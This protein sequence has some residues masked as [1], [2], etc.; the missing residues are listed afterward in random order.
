MVLPPSFYVASTALLF[1]LV[2][3]EL[4]YFAIARLRSPDVGAHAAN[5]AIFA[6]DPLLRGFTLA[7]RVATFCFVANLVPWS[8][9]A[10]PLTLLV[11]YVL[12]DFVYYWKHRFMHSFD[13]GWALHSTHHSSE[14]LTFF[15]TFRL[16]W[17]ESF[18]S[19]YAFLPLALLGLPALWLLLLIEINDGWQFVCHT[20]LVSRFKGLDRVF[21]TP[22]IHRVHHSRNPE[23]SQK[24]Y[25]STFMI[26]DRLFGTYHPG[27]EEVDAGVEGRSP[28]NHPLRIQFDGLIAWWRRRASRAAKLQ[29]PVR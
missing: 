11:A 8:L 13:L 20:D 12:V 26:W 2:M 29:R 9:E 5:G 15:A 1:L 4:T 17:I 10:T 23:L 27:L 3:A 21:N 19:Y 24:N 22:N 28:T 18:F 14:R 25:G 6:V 16:N 7:A